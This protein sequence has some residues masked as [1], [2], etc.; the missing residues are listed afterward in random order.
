MRRDPVSEL[1]FE[2]S[3][4]A[5]GPQI[6][7][8]MLTAAISEV[9][10]SNGDFCR[11]VAPIKED[12]G[13][14]TIH[15]Q[16]GPDFRVA[17]FANTDA[18][19]T[20]R[21]LIHGDEFPISQDAL[22]FRPHESHI[23]AGDKRRGE[24]APQTEVRFAFGVSQAR[25]ADFQHVGIVPMAGAGKRFEAG[26]QIQYVR[27]AHAAPITATVPAILNVAG[28]APEV[29]NIRAPEPR[30]ALPPFTDAEHDGPA[31]LPQ[32]VAHAGIRLFGGFI[33]MVAPVIFQIVHAPGGVGARVLN[34]MK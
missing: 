1:L 24:N 32:R 4:I 11:D 19:P 20:R 28:S 34:F 15:Q 33:R 13:P 16:F 18:L 22:D 30:L 7:N 26:L 2:F 5:S 14:G 3:K 21:I 29:A 25:V 9:G 6:A 31:G 8:D 17:G 12:N 27:E 23:V 10:P